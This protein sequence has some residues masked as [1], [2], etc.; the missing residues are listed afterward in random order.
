[1]TTAA[2]PVAGDGFSDAQRSRLV[3]LRRAIH[4]EPE[5]SFNEH[6][7]ADRMQAALTD[8]G[9][10]EVSRVA[11]TGLV[12]RVP[13]RERGAPVVAVRGDID[14][15]PVQ[16]ATG[17][18]FA[19]SVQGVMHACGHDVHATWAV[20]AAALLTA[21]PARGDVLVVLQPAE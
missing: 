21:N 19:S 9:I 3:D 17:L 12:A 13:G 4:R 2:A 20:G 1:M 16:E 5:L 7:T 15:L 6:A 10:H 8:L 18:P 11:R 14:A